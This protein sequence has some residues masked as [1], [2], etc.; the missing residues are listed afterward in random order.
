[1]ACLILD[2][3]FLFKDKYL[4]FFI[5]FYYI[6]KMKN[7]IELGQVFTNEKI[8]SQMMKLIKN[9]GSILEPSCGDGAFYNQ[10]K[11]CIGIEYDV[12]VCPEGAYNMDFFDFPINNKFNTIIGNPPYVKYSKINENTKQKLNMDLFDYRSNLYLFFIE[13]CIRHLEFGGE[14]IFIVPRDFIKATSSLKLN[15]FIYDNGT[16]TDWIEFG[17]E[18]IFKGFSP[19]CVIFR[20]E[21]DNFSKIT[22]GNLNFIENNGQLLFANNKYSNRFSDFFDVKVGA[23]SGNDK[24]FESSNGNQNFVYSKTKDSGKLKAMYYNI[25]HKDL[26]KY[27]EELKNRKIKKFNDNNWYMWGRGFYNSNKERIYVNCKTRNSQPFFLNDCNAYDGSIL[28][29]FPKFEIKDKEHLK[30]ICNELNN[31]DWNELGFKCG[32]RLLFN[33]KSLKNTIINKKFD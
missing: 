5:F 11:N 21:K 14:L 10:I 26:E 24:L 3:S 15:K 4:T 30:R 33:Q 25:A 17:D 28:A 29:I 32:G 20:F 13:K 23:V 7:V 9:K 22:N 2:G 6:I 16:I 18:I 31:I 12:N 8:V 27:K 1:M 19:N